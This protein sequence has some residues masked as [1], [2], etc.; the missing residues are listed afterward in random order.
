MIRD[1]APIVVDSE[2]DKLGPVT[3][4]KGLPPPSDQVHAVLNGNVAAFASP[5][6]SHRHCERRGL[7]TNRNNADIGLIVGACPANAATIA[8]APTAPT[9]IEAL[10]GTAV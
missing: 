3:I 8:I 10:D 4:W 9:L 6:D 7:A 2:S 5:I 1:G